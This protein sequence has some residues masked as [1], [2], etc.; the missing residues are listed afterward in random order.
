[1]VFIRAKLRADTSPASTSPADTSPA[2][3]TS[4]QQGAAAEMMIISV[5]YILLWLWNQFDL[6][7]Y[8][9]DNVLATEVVKFENE[10][11]KSESLLGD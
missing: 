5:F 1:M 4:S 3:Q 8:D 9:R 11:K 2:A 7:I 10:C 6:W